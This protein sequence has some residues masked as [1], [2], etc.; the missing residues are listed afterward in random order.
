[1]TPF[2]GNGTKVKNSSEI[3][4]PLIGGGGGGGFLIGGG[5]KTESFKLE[6]RN[7]CIKVRILNHHR[8]LRSSVKLDKKFH[9]KIIVLYSAYTV[10]LIQIQ[11]KKIID[12][13]PL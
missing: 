1:M 4:L 7:P 3:K 12:C 10:L 13:E 11:N 5:C 8:S 6:S 2:V 9:R